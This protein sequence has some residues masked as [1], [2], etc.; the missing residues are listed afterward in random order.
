[1]SWETP[2][3]MEAVVLH[4]REDARLERMPVPHAGPGEVR[5]RIGAALTCG[6]DL[7]VYRRGYHARM[8]VPPAIFGHEFAGVVDQ[9]GEG[10]VG[11]SASDRVV[12]AN[13]A[14]CGECPECRREREELC[15]DLLFL[16]GAYAGWVVVPERIV[17]KNLLSLPTGMPLESA[18][19]TEPLACALH[20]LEETDPRPGE[21]VA[22]LGA[23]PLG[24]LLA[25][26]AV[27]RGARV[28]V[29]GRRPGRLRAARAM[30]VA[31]VCDA[32]TEDPAAWVMARTENRGAERVIEAVG[33]P[34]AW[35]TA[36]SLTRKGGVVNLFG[37]CP[38][39][40]RIQVS[41][42]RLHYEAL[43][44]LG[45]FHHTPATIRAALALLATGAIPVDVLVEQDAPL[46][47]LPEL[48][49]EL[50]RGG[51]PL[52]VCLR[53]NHEELGVN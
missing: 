23:G 40:S 20:G 26:G 37:G 47:R 51:G 14:P 18:A 2:E 9:V 13:S 3:W 39:G 45:T 27:L 31:D 52:K 46:S 28:L 11:F 34:D 35:E 1:M 15:E 8:I 25:R 7:K 33:Q 38:A 36:I 4:G 48:L 30:G 24:L 42:D 22:I 16:N 21:T 41:T 10:V 32:A 44:L 17:R 43:T 12:A 50:A 5:V 49:P 6:T 19:L 53:P 29:I